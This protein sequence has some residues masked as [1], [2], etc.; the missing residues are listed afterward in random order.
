MTVHYDWLVEVL[1]DDLTDDPDIIDTLTFMTLEGARDWIAFVRPIHYRLGLV[2]DV[3]NDWNGLTDR[4]WAYVDA[5]GTL[6]DTFDGGASIPK[7]FLKEI[8]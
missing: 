8:G 6:P 1:E 4:Q 2:R 3:G 7:R 5:D